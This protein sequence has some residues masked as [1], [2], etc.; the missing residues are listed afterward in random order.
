MR[1]VDVTSFEAGG[2]IEIDSLYWVVCARDHKPFGQ[3]V[4]VVLIVRADYSGVLRSKA[5]Q[6]DNFADAVDR[7]EE[8]MVVGSDTIDNP[9]LAELG[10]RSSWGVRFYS[11][12]L[13][14]PRI[15]SLDFPFVQVEHFFES[16]FLFDWC[17]RQVCHRLELLG[18][19]E[20]PFRRVS[21][22]S[23]AL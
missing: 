13:C 10:C 23:I 9:I 2:C 6:C 14:L 12:R 18:F 22:E 16:V 15:G 21:S 19:L 11:V 4:L 1:V 20:Q 5:S 7:V 3:F 17:G 8:Q